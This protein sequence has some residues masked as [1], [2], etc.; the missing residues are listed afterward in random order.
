MK[1][2]VVAWLVVALVLL[3]VGGA[4]FA[5][6]FS[7]LSVNTAADINMSLNNRYIDRDETIRESFTGVLVDTEDCD[8]TLVSC[9]ETE[10]PR[11]VI[12]ELEKTPHSIAV[13][14]GVLKIKMQDKRGWLDFVGVN[15]SN[16]SITL[17]L[18][19]KQY[20]SVN[21]STATGGVEIGEN[22]S[23]EE[24]KITSDTGSISCSAMAVDRLE[25]KSNTGKIRIQACAPETLQLTA[26]TGDVEVMGMAACDSLTAK[27]DTGKV[28]LK[29]VACKTLDAKTAT[30]DVEL[31]QVTAHVQMQLS[32][33]TGC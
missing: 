23:A 18:P 1:K 32:S 2:G 24:A 13:E 29:D 11:V 7:G 27:S 28:L 19:Q 9:P 14:N 15:L 16:M 26:N 20:A 17:Y 31:Q 5:L 6:G 22:I 8:V 4:L 3:V 10:S 30:G 21:I 12:R 25:G 33:E